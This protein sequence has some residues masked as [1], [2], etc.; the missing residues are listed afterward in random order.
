HNLKIESNKFIRLDRNSIPAEIVNVDKT[1]FD[2]RNS[3][4]IGEDM[5]LSNNDLKF[6][7]GYDHPMILNNNGGDVIELYSEDSKIKMAMETTEPV[8]ILYCSNA[9]DE[10]IPISEGNLTFKYQ[11]VCLETQWYPDA[12]NHDFLEKK[13]LKPG[14]NYY[15]RTKY[16]FSVER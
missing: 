7:K 10:G 5:N 1:P 12:L 3:K 4:K 15:S 13:T 11:G 9:I 8:V 16:K 14:E 2:F 6:T